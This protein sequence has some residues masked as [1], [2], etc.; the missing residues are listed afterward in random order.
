M[1]TQPKPSGDRV[2]LPK[3]DALAGPDAITIVGTP[4]ALRHPAPDVTVT[5]Q[6]GPRAHGP[7]SPLARGSYLLTPPCGTPIV[8]RR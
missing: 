7:R 8:V 3:A 5:E 2:S 4:M 6:G 1:I